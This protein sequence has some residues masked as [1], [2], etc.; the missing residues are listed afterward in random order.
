MLLTKDSTQHEHLEEAKLAARTEAERDLLK[1]QLEEAELKLQRAVD[2]RERT[3]Q[4]MKEVEHKL[5]RAV[6]DKER[7]NQMLR[8]VEHKLERAG[9]ERERANKNL[10][11]MESK[12]Q[13][14]GEERDRLSKA[15]TDNNQELK[16][17]E[18]VLTGKSRFNY[19]IRMCRCRNARKADK[20]IYFCK[21]SINVPSKLYHIEN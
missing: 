13:R 18:K 3:N 4:L 21:I 14:V 10:M 12:L 6:D 17:M 9:E 19:S 16:D 2:D 15:L 5:D 11:E 20:Q 1:R 8:E 7:T